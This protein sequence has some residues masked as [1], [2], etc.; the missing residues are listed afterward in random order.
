ML[1]SVMAFTPVESGV[2]TLREDRKEGQSK[3][4]YFLIGYFLMI[5][6]NKRYG[7]SIEWNFYFLI[8]S[9]EFNK[10]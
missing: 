5:T 2:Q 9:V 8:F 4:D 3:N 10:E 7:L 6:H 1:T